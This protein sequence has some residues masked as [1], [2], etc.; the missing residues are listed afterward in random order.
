VPEQNVVPLGQFTHTP[1]WQGP[2]LQ[3]LPQA[4]Q[5]CGSFCAL[6]QLPPHP[7]WPLGHG[8]QL[9]KHREVLGQTFPQLPQFCVSEAKSTQVWTPLTVHVP[10]KSPGHAHVLPPPKIGSQ[11]A[12]TGQQ[13]QGAWKLGHTQ[14]PFWH[15]KVPPQAC[16]Q[17]PQLFGSV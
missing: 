3:T 10:G 6:T 12:P 4:P 7:I 5:F 14:A 16:P 11:V 8:W 13:P 15:W 17:V 1:F 9:P 2:F